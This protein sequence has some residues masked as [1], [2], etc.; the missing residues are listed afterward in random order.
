MTHVPRQTWTLNQIQLF[1]E[2]VT[3]YYQPVHKIQWAYQRSYDKWRC[4]QC[5]YKFHTM[6]EEQPEED[7]VWIYTYVS[8]TDLWSHHTLLYHYCLTCI[9][10]QIPHPSY[11]LHVPRED[12]LDGT[13]LKKI[14]TSH[15]RQWCQTVYPLLIHYT[16]PVDIIHTLFTK[17]K[18]DQ[19]TF[20]LTQVNYILRRVVIPCIKYPEWVLCTAHRLYSMI[21]DKWTINPLNRYVGRY[22]V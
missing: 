3:I 18:Q 6:V 22:A 15:L 10:E 1:P 5:G 14:R 7:L 9:W 11:P 13:N 8:E 19:V 12:W 17:I 21:Y 20:S 16:S 2:T 4:T